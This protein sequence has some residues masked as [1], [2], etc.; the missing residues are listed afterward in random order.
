MKSI[1]L[2]FGCCQCT[3]QRKTPGV[4]VKVVLDWRTNTGKNNNG[5]KAAMNLL[6]GAGIPVRIVGAYK[7]LHDKV[8]ISDG[9][10]TEVGSFNY[11][12]TADHSNSD[13]MFV[14]W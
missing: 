2:L 7:I 14:V 8:I 11:S 9:C 1:C 12:R 13:N 6:A 4:D 10:Y 3:C 5:S